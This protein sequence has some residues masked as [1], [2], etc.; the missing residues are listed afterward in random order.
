[1]INHFGEIVLGLIGTSFFTLLWK[2]LDSIDLRFVEI[3]A[4]IRDVGTRVERIQT[5]L[6]SFNRELGVHDRRLDEIQGKTKAS[7]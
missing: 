2:R 6:S 1:M 3:R 5:D 7:S 4:D